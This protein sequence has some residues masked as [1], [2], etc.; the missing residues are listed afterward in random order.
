MLHYYQL[1]TYAI[2]SKIIMMHYMRHVMLHCLQKYQRH[3]IFILLGMA[4]V[5]TD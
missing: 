4:T 5:G 1:S 3:S 2:A